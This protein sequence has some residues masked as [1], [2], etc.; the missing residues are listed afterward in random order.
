MS[1]VDSATPHAALEARRAGLSSLFSDRKEGG[2]PPLPDSLSVNEES[3]QFPFAALGSRGSWKD[4]WVYF[5]VG[6]VS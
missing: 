5:Q 4:L 2:P 1:L 6:S 3:E